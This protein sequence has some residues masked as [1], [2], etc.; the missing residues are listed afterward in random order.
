[1]RILAHR[2]FRRLWISNGVSGIGSWLLVVAIPFHVFQL[3]GSAVAT[4]LTLAL[5]ALPALIVGPWAGVLLDRWNL[6]RAMWLAD[7]ASAAAVALILFADSAERVW[8]VY[9]AVLAE[10]LATTV[11]RPAAR[12]LTPTVVGTGKELAAA[13]ALTA[14]SGSVIRLT[15]PPLGALLLAGPGIDFVLAV[16][17]A[18][19]LLSAAIIATISRQVRPEPQPGNGFS[20]LKQGLRYVGRSKV[21]RGI[22]LAN[23]VF[24]TANAGLT[25][26]LVPFTVDRLN[27]PG[28]A[29][30]YL[31]SGLGMGYLL[32]AAISSRALTWLGV[33]DLLIATQV[34]TGCAFFALVNAPSLPWAM[35]AA[36]LIGLPGS[37][38]L[39]TA[40]TTVQRISPTELLGRIGALF[41]AVDSLTVVIG[42]LAAPAM[43]TLVGLPLTLNLLAAFAVLAA[44]VTLLAVPSHPAHL[45]RM[46]LTKADREVSDQR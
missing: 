18:S 23:G 28:Y 17:I 22:L 34:A 29:V 6:S 35:V 10:N 24:L 12:A 8:L 27:A 5:E 21:L 44:P 43:T 42:A 11:F 7:L 1:M 46:R 14:V 3:T 38:L 33:R 2:D 13:N 31:I 15:A 39:I 26:L 20:Q 4:G 30:G 32:G 9:I 36:A 45:T 41:F 19:Y 16:D 25:A 37:V 40:E